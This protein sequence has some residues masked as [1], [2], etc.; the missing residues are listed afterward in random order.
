MRYSLIL[1][2]I[3]LTAI[4]MP[5]LADGIL[6][7]PNENGDDHL[8]PLVGVNV[9]VDIHDQ[10]AITTVR[11]SFLNETDTVTS[12]LY[13][14]RVP[15]TASVTGF[16]IWQGDS[17]IEFDLHP[18]EQGGPGGGIDDDADLREFLGNNPFTAPL[19]SIPPGLYM[20]HLQYVQLL[21]YDFG[22]MQFRYPLFTGDWLPD[23][24]DTVQI[25]VS[26]EA[27]R[28][29]TELSVISLEDH[30]ASEIAD[31]HHAV[32]VLSAEDITPEEDWGVDI[33]YDQEDIGAWLF[34]HRSDPE[35]M[36]YFLLVIEPGIV[37]TGEAV[38][39]YFT[40]VLDRSGSMSGAKIVQARQS[41][42]NCFDHLLQHDFFNIID[43]ASDVRL[44]SNEMLSATQDNLD[45]AR[46]YVGRIEAGGMTN[47]YGA[48]I[49]AISQDMGENAANQIIFTT[50]GL[51]TA[52]QS[53]NPAVI[54]DNR[55]WQLIIGER[56]CHCCII[57]SNR[58]T[59]RHGSENNGNRM[60]A[61]VSIG[62]GI[63]S[64]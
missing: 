63:N 7:I 50:D 36:G 40:F 13:H 29:I 23:P 39:K 9:D 49:Q 21:P 56:N 52:G 1:M 14:F 26:I 6:R 59:I 60:E 32:V 43:F 37:D 33:L 10:I 61:S 51:P 34:T 24:I 35:D 53:T 19:D 48:L 62:V 44:Y 12:A 64:Q 28:A 20:V 11:N 15:S 5:L 45:D 22:E 25:N 38:P 27:Q 42:L 47:T 57:P 4:S 16:G 2:V 8:C 54:E 31:E 58:H 55:I 30:T 18:G 17:L 41:V 46:N 3:C